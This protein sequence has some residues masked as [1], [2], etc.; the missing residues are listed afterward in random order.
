MK[1]DITNKLIKTPCKKINLDIG[2][3]IARKLVVFIQ[4]FNKKNDKKAAGI[5]ANQLG[6]DASV[7]VVLIKNKPLI[8]INPVITDFSKS[9]FAHEEEC[10]SFPDQRITVFRHDWIKVKSDYSKEEMFFGQLENM[11]INKTNLFESALI[12][13]EIAHLFG[14]TIHDFQWENSPSPREW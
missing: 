5:A 14:K 1:I 8:L 4:N 3:K 9:K 10:L 6:I 7:V 12:Q 13:H 2:R 11:D